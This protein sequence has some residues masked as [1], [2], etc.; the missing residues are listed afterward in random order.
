MEFQNRPGLLYTGE[1]GGRPHN[2][3]RNTSIKT[4]KT[5]KNIR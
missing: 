4:K 2:G 1:G 3:P 5:F